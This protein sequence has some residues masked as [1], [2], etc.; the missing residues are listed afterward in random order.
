MATGSYKRYLPHSTHSFY[1]GC[2]QNPD[3]V[4]VHYLNVPYP[5][6]N[7]L[8]TVAPSLALWADKKEWTKDELVSQLKPMFFS[9]D[10]HDLNNELEISVSRI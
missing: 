4:L 6:D 5:D 9:E 3:I 2:L 8:A 1:N 7:K 10:E